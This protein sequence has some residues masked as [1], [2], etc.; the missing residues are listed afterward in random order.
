MK[1]AQT[2]RGQGVTCAIDGNGFM[3]PACKAEFAA[4]IVFRTKPLYR[5]V[6]RAARSAR[7]SDELHDGLCRKSLRPEIRALP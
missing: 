3:P 1:K 2:R 4:G 7:A 6:R 5:L